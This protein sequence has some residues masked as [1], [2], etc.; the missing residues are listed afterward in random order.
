MT[1]LAVAASILVGA[2]V[3]LI[4]PLK[5]CPKAPP[6]AQKYADD[7]MGYVL[8]GVGIVF[9][10]GLVIAIAALVAGR[11]VNM[12]HAT[13]MGIVGIVMVI[14][15]AIA[16]VVAPGIVDGILGNGCI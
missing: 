1:S 5:V 15:A 11:I 13:K 4:I 10:L 16:Y 2:I 6:G 3:R 8:W 7:V 14:V 9:F 12:P